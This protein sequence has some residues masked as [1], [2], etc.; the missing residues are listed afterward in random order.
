MGR[1]DTFPLRD[2]GVARS[3]SL[4][5]GEMH[6][7]QGELLERLGDMRGMLYYHLLLSRMRNLQKKRA[8]V[9]AERLT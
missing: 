2:S 3:L 9:P 1:L 7:D 4:L 8:G 6:V 5:A